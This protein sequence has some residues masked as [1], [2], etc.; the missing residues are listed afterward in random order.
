MVVEG[1]VS[2]E[3]WYLTEVLHMWR[4]AHY[5]RLRDRSL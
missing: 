4:N 5:G 3:R 1:L 2:I